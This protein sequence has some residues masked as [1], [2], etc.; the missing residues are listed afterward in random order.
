MIARAAWIRSGRWMDALAEELR[1]HVR[2]RLSASKHALAATRFVIFAQARTGS[3][4][5][6]SLLNAHYGFYCDGEI[7][8]RRRLLPGSFIAARCKL[9]REDAYGFKVKL[10][11]LRGQ[12]IRGAR[13]F[14]RDLHEDGWRTI[15]L[16]RRNILRQTIS[17]LVAR[18]RNAWSHRSVD[19]PLALGKIHIDCGDLIR[20]MR[21]H[22]DLTTREQEVLEGLSPMTLVYEDHLLRS[23]VQQHTADRV[24][25]Y[26]SMPSVPVQTNLL[27]IT[28]DRLSDFVENYEELVQAVSRTEYAEFLC[29]E[30]IP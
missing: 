6:V 23:E 1:T 21:R 12:N 17:G 28:S 24:F 2:V 25:D 16:Q 19:D 11:Q 7:L 22:H 14:M 4:L 3:T 30:Y 27:R 8:A 10:A 9:C 5:L 15:Y 26:L 18:H 13:Q 29:G 20:G